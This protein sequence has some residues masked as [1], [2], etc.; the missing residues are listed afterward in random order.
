MG[1]GGDP[2]AW[3]VSR[4]LADLEPH[5][6]PA[7]PG[8]GAVLPARIPEA[9][10]SQ[11]GGLRFACDAA[12]MDTDMKIVRFAVGRKT[13]Y[14]ILSGQAI[15]AID[16]GPFRQLRLADEH[17]RLAEV[18]LLAPCLPSKIVAVPNVTVPCG[19]SVSLIMPVSKSVP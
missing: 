9:V 1:Q 13:G 2:A 11:F 15:Q 5:G 14:G 8:T 6:L 18:R 10:A 12:R 7:G 4:E 3:M 17:Y 16:G 19:A